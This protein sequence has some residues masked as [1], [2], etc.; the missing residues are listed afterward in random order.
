[1]S[2][3]LP[4]VTDCQNCGSPA[5][6]NYC[7]ACGQDSRDHTVS[8]RLLF[9]DLASD[10]F[11]YDSRFFRSFV[12]LLFKPGALT[13]EYT[14]GRRVRFIPPLRLYIFVSILFFFVVSVQVSDSMRDFDERNAANAPSDSLLVERVLSLHA[15][16]PDTLGDGTT[17]VSWIA[18]RLPLAGDDS[19]EPPED[20]DWSKVDWDTMDW[21]EV[22][23]GDNLNF[24]MLGEP[25]SLNK[26]HF[27]QSI[28]KVVPKLVFLLLPMF[29]LLLALVYIRH[30]R[31]FIEHLILSLHLHAFM[32]LVFTMALVLQ[33]DWFVLVVFILIHIYIFL[34]LRRVYTQGWVKTA[35]K[36]FFLTSAYN[37]IL[38]ALV[39][40]VVVSTAQLMEL[41]AEHP[42]LVQ[43]ILG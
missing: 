42:L 24:T 41:S 1:M 28:Q 23:S 6:G 2:E 26:Q 43:W 9:Q 30:R 34:A 19:F 29:A 4:K 18:E 7:P 33:N 11:T 3:L 12:P 8:M 17:V 37:F 35:L 38:V 21:D 13:K 27:I 32:F 16:A 5:E 39:V 15:A 14:Q 22:E 25:T 10:V 36:F 20:G 31:K 40:L